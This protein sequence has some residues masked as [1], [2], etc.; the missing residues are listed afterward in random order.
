M[1]PVKICF[2]FQSSAYF[3]ILI[4]VHT[5]VISTFIGKTGIP[6]YNSIK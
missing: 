2:M 3:I 6:K 5:K 4:I 1:V